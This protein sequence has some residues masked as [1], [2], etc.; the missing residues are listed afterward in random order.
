[1][2]FEGVVEHGELQ[3]VAIV[4]IAGYAISTRDRCHFCP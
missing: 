3:S 2:G 1:L 4:F